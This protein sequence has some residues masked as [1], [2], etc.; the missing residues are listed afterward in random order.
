MT[1][2]E[3]HR[4]SFLVGRRYQFRHMYG[5]KNGYYGWFEVEKITFW[6]DLKFRLKVNVVLINDGTIVNLSETIKSI[7]GNETTFVGMRR[8]TNMDFRQFLD[9]KRKLKTLV[10]YVGMEGYYVSIGKLVHVGAD[11]F[12]NKVKS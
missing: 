11:Y 4:L 9:V 7:K 5:P 3:R 2:A 12:K 10:E 1:K 6:E 8:R